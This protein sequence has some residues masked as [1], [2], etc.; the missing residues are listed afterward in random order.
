MQDY[1]LN[2]LVFMS[3]SVVALFNY[4]FYRNVLH[5]SVFYSGLWIFIL[6][7][8]FF[9]SHGLFSLSGEFLLIILFSM[10]LFSTGGVFASYSESRKGCVRCG[11]AGELIS[12]K[13][14]Y[15]LYLLVAAVGLPFFIQKSMSLA[16]HA[17]AESFIQNIRI[18]LTHEDFGQTYGLLA[19]LFPVSI[20]SL[21]LMSLDR[22]IKL[23]SILFLQL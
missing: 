6:G 17:T 20:S 1:F 8:Y 13:I 5:P 2:I 12:V 3:A 18:S 21:L 19:Y 15:K 7:L 10:I 22:G 11:S 9:T 23:N 14:F 16:G 4:V